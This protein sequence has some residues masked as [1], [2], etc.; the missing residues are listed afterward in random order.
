MLL[1][2]F[3]NKLLKRLNCSTFSVFWDRGEATRA[4]LGR[5]LHGTGKSAMTVDPAEWFEVLGNVVGTVV[6]GEERITTAEL[7]TRHLGVPITDRAARRLRRVMRRLGWSPRKLRFGKETKNG[8]RRKAG[9][10]PMTK[11]PPGSISAPRTSEKVTVEQPAT[12]NM[13]GELASVAQLGLRNLRDIL[14][15]PYDYDD[16]PL[17]RAKNAA[18]QT[19]LN[20][21]LRAD[22]DRLQ[23]RP[24]NTL[25]KL[26]QIIREEE[27]RM[28][29]QS[30]V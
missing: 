3:R 11:Q 5:K 19:A 23:P 10:T 25:A 28:T 1:I 16:G 12:E 9:I 29:G 22:Q 27:R 13:A 18:A 21:Q 30:S 17:L 26:L 7:L 24:D 8:Y 14:S 6:N 4:S 20:A 15:A 2:V